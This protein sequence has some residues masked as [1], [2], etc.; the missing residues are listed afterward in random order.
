MTCIV[1]NKVCCNSNFCSSIRNLSFFSVSAFKFTHYLCL[2]FN[3]LCIVFVILKYYFYCLGFSEI[4]GY[5]FC[6]VLLLLENSSLLTL[7]IFLHKIISYFSSSS[8]VQVTCILDHLILSHSSWMLF[9]VCFSYIFFF[10][11]VD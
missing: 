8:G 2:F 4:L 7:Y 1:S 3:N 6:H 5:I 9:S 10:Y 11:Q